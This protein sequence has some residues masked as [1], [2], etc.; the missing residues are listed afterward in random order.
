M[1]LPL[2][3]FGPS[4]PTQHRQVGTPSTKATSPC[5]AHPGRMLAQAIKQRGAARQPEACAAFVPQPGPRPASTP[6]PAS[7][8]PARFLG[9]RVIARRLHAMVA[10]LAVVAFAAAVC[11]ATCQAP[12]NGIPATVTF[13]TPAGSGA[14]G[15]ADDSACTT[16]SLLLQRYVPGGSRGVQATECFVAPGP[17]ALPPSIGSQLNFTT[18]FTDL[19]LM[20]EYFKAL[21][22]EGVWRVRGGMGRDSK[23]GVWRVGGGLRRD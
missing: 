3:H 15:L 16:L 12:P 21:N 17:P 7:P 4:R 18:Y 2:S 6:R 11:P 14:G 1:H 20:S 22:N 19:R 9:Q 10:L 8:P 13:A 5:C 23:A